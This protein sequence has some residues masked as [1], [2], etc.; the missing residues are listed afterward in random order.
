M[1]CRNLAEC[2][3]EKFGFEHVEVPKKD[4]KSRFL[5]VEDRILDQPCARMLLADEG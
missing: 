5:L 4:G 1:V 2:L 3:V